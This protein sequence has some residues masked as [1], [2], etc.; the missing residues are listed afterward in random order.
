MSVR[1]K[2]HFDYFNVSK[3]QNN[4]KNSVIS[5]SRLTIQ[6]LYEIP[7]FCKINL[8]MRRIR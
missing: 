4:F 3:V 8:L 5:F 1:S 2:V 7:N 6:K